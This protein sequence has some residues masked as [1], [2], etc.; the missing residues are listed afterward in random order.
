MLT[1][2]LH[3]IQYGLSFYLFCPFP[4]PIC[5][6]L[7]TSLWQKKWDL[8]YVCID[9]FK[10]ALF[11]SH[12]RLRDSWE[13]CSEIIVTCCPN[14][15]EPLNDLLRKKAN[16]N[17]KIRTTRRSKSGASS[18]CLSPSLRPLCK[19][20]LFPQGA[21]TVGD[22]SQTPG[23]HWAFKIILNCPSREVP[24][25]LSMDSHPSFSV[26]SVMD[27]LKTCI[28]G[29]TW[30]LWQRKKQKSNKTRRHTYWNYHCLL[31]N[32]AEQYFLCMSRRL[33]RI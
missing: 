5:C 28:P 12:L 15:I 30:E 10:P 24:D 19:D 7:S 22:L 27:C 11:S 13:G 3:V 21:E 2:F 29:N 9:C 31:V 16:K 32:N 20:V 33:Q 8:C 25:I 17:I 6:C 18:K 23:K 1:T 26:G 14:G 4:K